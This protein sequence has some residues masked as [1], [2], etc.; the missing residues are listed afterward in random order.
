MKRRG[1]W[2]R[3]ENNATLA[4]YSSSAAI[5]QLP[6]RLS[7]TVTFT[8]YCSCRVSE[9]PRW[10]LLS[11]RS[12]LLDSFNEFVSRQDMNSKAQ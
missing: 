5:T 2:G 11:D 7:A 4:T 10:S 3:I 1:V 12:H 6:A 8:A 9:T